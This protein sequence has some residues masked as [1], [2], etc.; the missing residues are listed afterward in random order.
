MNKSHAAFGVLCL[1][2]GTALAGFIAGRHTSALPSLRQLE[3]RIGEAYEIDDI[4]ES[5]IALILWYLHS[6]LEREQCT[7]ETF[8]KA[9]NYTGMSGNIAG[10][11]KLLVQAKVRDCYSPALER[12]ASKWRARI[13]ELSLR[14]ERER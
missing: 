11:E 6:E 13:N 8:A 3:D 14:R 7:T 5:D 10:V 4:P 9:I 2:A 12:D 1:I